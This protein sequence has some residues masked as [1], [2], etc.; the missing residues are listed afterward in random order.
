MLFH[1]KKFK[2]RKIPLSNFCPPILYNFIKYGSIYSPPI[3]SVY[4]NSVLATYSQYQE[5]LILDCIFNS[6][7]DGT[8]VDI[9][10]NDPDLFSNTKRFYDKGWSGI[11]IEPTPH[12]FDSI[13]KKR[14]RDI[15]LNIG[16]G[17]RNGELT[18][19]ELSANTLS[20]FSKEAALENCKKYNSRIEKEYT[21]KIKPLKEIFEK[22]LS[23]KSVDFLSV[24]TEGFELEV[25]ES[26]DWLIHRPRAIMIELNQNENKIVEFLS[27]ISYSL[28]YNNFTNGIFIDKLCNL[29]VL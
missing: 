13:C 12:L 28:I 7:K 15:N 16:I 4:T 20:T 24:D 9:G 23:E 19:Y 18:F 3:R 25:L 27:S 6:K 26:N 2:I 5:D 11:N 22:Y 14:L 1:I 10:A 8:Y 29:N 17:K 21:V